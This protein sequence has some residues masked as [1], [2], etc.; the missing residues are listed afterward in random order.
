MTKMSVDTSVPC[1]E[2]DG[3]KVVRE[4]ILSV[5]NH[6]IKSNTVVLEV[7]GVSIS[8]LAEHLEKAISN[9]TKN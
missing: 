1:L 8:V 6:P 4:Q 5:R 7:Q 2:V 3:A 9:A